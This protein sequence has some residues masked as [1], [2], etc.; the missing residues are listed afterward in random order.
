MAKMRKV[1]AV[2]GYGA[3]VGSQPS[4]EVE[5]TTGTAQD[6][7]GSKQGGGVQDAAI[8]AAG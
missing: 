2:R 4:V 3:F 6:K 5:E 8:I 7:T 1:T